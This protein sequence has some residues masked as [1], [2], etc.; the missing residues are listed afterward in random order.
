MLMFSP[1]VSIALAH[2][3]ERA[4]H[5]RTVLSAEAVPSTSGC[6]GSHRSWSTE[7]WWPL[8]SVPVERPDGSRAQ[9]RTC[10]RRRLPGRWARRRGS[11][12]TWCRMARR[13]RAAMAR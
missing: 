12:G 10:E 11:W 9:T 7:S 6:F 13:Q 2:L 5:M 4:S 8:S 3:P 1:L